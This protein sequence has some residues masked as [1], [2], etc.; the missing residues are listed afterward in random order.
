MEIDIGVGSVEAFRSELVEPL[1]TKEEQPCP[2]CGLTLIHPVYLGDTHGTC[3]G[4]QPSGQTR[5]DIALVREIDRIGRKEW[6]DGFWIGIGFA[7]TCVVSA[8][9][10]WRWWLL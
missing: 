3:Y 10:A 1:R 7:S 8:F 9:A 5:L 2:V 6:W 4:V